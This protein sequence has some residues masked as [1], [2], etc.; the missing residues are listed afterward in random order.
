METV[1]LSSKIK[2]LRFASETLSVISFKF[3]V[4]D[5]K[6]FN[7]FSME[8]ELFKIIEFKL[9]VVSYKDSEILLKLTILSC[10]EIFVSSFNNSLTL[11]ITLSAF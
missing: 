2:S 7:E 11:S 6:F 9:P 4:D 3:S 1:E 10:N 8:L 5:S